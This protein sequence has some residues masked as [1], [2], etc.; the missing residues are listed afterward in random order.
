MA[1]ALAGVL[2]RAWTQGPRGSL[3]TSA[4]AKARAARKASLC[5][6]A[7]AVN[8][9]NL[10]ATAHIKFR[11]DPFGDLM[12]AA[13]LPASSRDTQVHACTIEALEDVSFPRPPSLMCED[14]LQ[15]VY[16]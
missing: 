6:K 9:R 7:L 16:P 5:L 2:Q 12:M 14:T 13:A 10:R 8:R 1:D 4:E 11:V 15:V 3:S